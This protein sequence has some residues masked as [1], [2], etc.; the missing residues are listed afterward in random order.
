MLI[1]I[2]RLYNPLLWIR[3]YLSNNI[4]KNNWLKPLIF[5]YT[6]LTFALFSYKIDYIKE[7]YNTPKKNSIILR[8]NINNNIK[9]KPYVDSTIKIGLK[10]LNI[11]GVNIIVK[12]LI[13]DQ[14]TENYLA[15]VKKYND[16][17]YVIWIDD[18]SKDKT[19]LTLSHELIHIN[20]Y[21]TKQLIIE[22]NNI[23]WE[24]KKYYVKENLNYYLRPWEYEA[25]INEKKLYYLI[26]EKL[27]E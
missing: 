13:H 27:N 18:M 26:K 3:N 14:R 15:Y 17:D 23:Y 22:D 20:Q 7:K 9:N 1:K 21:Y 24:H 2:G 25:S 12:E 10:K 19:I 16:I 8:N 6:L 4:Q 5:L 11:I